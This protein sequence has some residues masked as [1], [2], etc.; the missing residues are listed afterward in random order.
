NDRISALAI[1]GNFFGNFSTAVKEFGGG[2]GNDD[3]TARA[4]VYSNVGL[5]ASNYLDGGA[6]NDYLFASIY[7]DSNVAAPQGHNV[8][9]GGAGNDTLI[10]D[11]S[12]SL[13]GE[14]G[15]STMTSEL[16]GGSGNDSLVSTIFAFAEDTA[17][18]INE[19]AG[20]S[21]NDELTASIVA[22]TLFSFVGASASN[23]LSGG[24]GNDILSAYANA[25]YHEPYY[26]DPE[27][28]GTAH[29]FLDGGH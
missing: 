25:D 28:Y 3:V 13:D 10:S 26:D 24:A 5:L 27:Y 21:G 11:N 23:T 1:G 12:A 29:N 17:V 9:I 6:G 7:A 2:T 22:G 19:L 14:N 16:S 8:L 4:I 18:G 15:S 20:G